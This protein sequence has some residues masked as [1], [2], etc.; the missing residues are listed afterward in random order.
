MDLNSAIQDYFDQ[1][2]KKNLYKFRVW[3]GDDGYY[4]TART[5]REPASLRDVIWNGDEYED[6]T[7]NDA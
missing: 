2:G 4:C 6:M 7:A 5:I 1:E 3:L